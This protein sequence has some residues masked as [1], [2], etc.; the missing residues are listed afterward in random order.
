MNLNGHHAYLPKDTINFILSHLDIISLMTTRTICQYIHQTVD[1]IIHE[2]SPNYFYRHL[3]RIPNLSLQTL[4]SYFKNVSLSDND[5]HVKFAHVMLAA[6][7]NQ[8]IEF[9]LEII[10]VITQKNMGTTFEF[11]LNYRECVTM[12]TFL[13]KIPTIKP[14]IRIINFY[15]Y[16]K[17]WVL[18]ALSVS[19]MD[20]IHFMYPH[21]PVRKL[22]LFINFTTYFDFAND[23]FD[24]KTKTYYIEYMDLFE[25]HYK[26]MMYQNVPDDF[27][28]GCLYAPQ[29]GK[30]LKNHCDVYPY[31][32][33]ALY[34]GHLTT[35]Y[36]LIKN[37]FPHQQPIQMYKLITTC[38]L[39]CN[40]IEAFQNYVTDIGL[41]QH[42]YK[43]LNQELKVDDIFTNQ[44]ADG[45]NL[46]KLSLA[47]FDFYLQKFGL[48][49]KI[50]DSDCHIGIADIA[51]YEKYLT[52]QKPKWI[53]AA[54]QSNQDD[55]IKLLR[56]KGFV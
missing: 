33:C 5:R 35:A 34:G 26:K 31:L 52:D 28:Y 22:E 41:H 16:C 50:P 47:T 49:G 11:Y 44:Y 37:H 51:I 18:S 43:Y 2:D 20:L 53:G 13:K 12:N 56:E 54:I 19:D 45:I 24:K 4:Q 15:E 1:K 29:C 27:V 10:N 38:L 6:F 48:E 39:R 8:H 21:A 32:R 36:R 30:I 46:P 9:V 14:Y 7:K 42:L 25:N 40:H 23:N 55:L 3:F 17:I